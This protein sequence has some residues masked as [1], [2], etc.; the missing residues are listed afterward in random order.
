M[1]RKEQ[2]FIR[3][4]NQEVAFF[5]YMLQRD[6]KLLELHHIFSLAMRSMLKM[7]YVYAEGL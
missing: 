2:N 1:C 7:K 4:E 3:N 5:N 6:F